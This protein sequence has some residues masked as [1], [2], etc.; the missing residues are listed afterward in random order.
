MSLWP[1]WLNMI[2]T[3]AHKGCSSKKVRSCID[4][5]EFLY[6]LHMNIY[7]LSS[8]IA[9]VQLCE[10]LHAWL[11]QCAQLYQW[12]YFLNPDFKLR[13]SFL[14]LGTLSNVWDPLVVTPDTSTLVWFD[15]KMKLEFFGFCFLSFFLPTSF[16]HSIKYYIPVVHQ[17][18]SSEV[19][20]L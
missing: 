9:V 10:L 17:M 8:C 6:W 16:T 14:F 4:S 13:H 7:L 11:A 18:G 15:V 19:D 5:D 2:W 1:R 20:N 12:C 3:S